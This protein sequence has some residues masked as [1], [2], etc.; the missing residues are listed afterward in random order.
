MALAQL[1]KQLAIAI[2]QR[3][4][5]DRERFAARRTLDAMSPLKVSAGAMHW[6][7]TVLSSSNRANDATPGDRLTVSYRTALARHRSTAD[8]GRHNE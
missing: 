5:A 4:A 1:H 2:R 7:N 6:C 3:L 8:G